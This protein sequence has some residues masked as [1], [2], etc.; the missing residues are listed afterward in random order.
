MLSVGISK[1]ICKMASQKLNRENIKIMKSQ[2]ID[3]RESG[4]KTF[5]F[6]RNFR[7]FGNLIDFNV[8]SF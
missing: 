6:L 8:F 7:N 4:L 5:T 2:V 1:L 3:A